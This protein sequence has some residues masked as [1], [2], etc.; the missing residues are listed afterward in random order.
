[1][2]ILN[3]IGAILKLG[4]EIIG[5]IIIFYML[6]RYVFLPEVFTIIDVI[7]VWFSF[8]GIVCFTLSSLF[9]LSD[10]FYFKRIEY[11]HDSVKT[12]LL[13]WMTPLVVTIVGALFL[14]LAELQH[15]L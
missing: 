7:G 3:T 14:I 6:P 12:V 11:S 13:M 9:F 2:K 10:I 4:I 8:L 1:M 5:F 15:S